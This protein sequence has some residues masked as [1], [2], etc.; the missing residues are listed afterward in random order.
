MVE[1]EYF[2]IEP[3]QRGRGKV[4]KRLG[5]DV[6]VGCEHRHGVDADAFQKEV[7]V[8]ETQV[9]CAIDS[10]AVLLLS[11]EGPGLPCA[12]GIEG[13]PVDR[14]GHAERGADGLAVV[15]AGDRVEVLQ[16]AVA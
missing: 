2:L 5:R 6:V 13:K 12:F 7:V 16:G 15:A 8:V 3:F 11:E 9:G 10:G 14:R 1:D 4:K